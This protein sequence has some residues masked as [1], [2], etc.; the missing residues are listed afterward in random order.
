MFQS[1]RLIL[2]FFINLI[3]LIPIILKFSSVNVI[4]LSL[5]PIID[6]LIFFFSIFLLGDMNIVQ[7]SKIL[8]AKNL[9]KKVTI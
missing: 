4:F 2:D 5:I 7:L 6:V 8:K 1:I 3:L 9:L